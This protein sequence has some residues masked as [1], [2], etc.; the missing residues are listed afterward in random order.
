ML[1]SAC[2]RGDGRL[3]FLFGV[4]DTHSANHTET[5]GAVDNLMVGAMRNMAVGGGHN[6]V[7]GGDQAQSI[8]GSERR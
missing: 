7:I 3:L 8:G 5:I 1:P 6:V 4:Y 2:V